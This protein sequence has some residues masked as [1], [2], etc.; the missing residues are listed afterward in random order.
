MRN[1][2]SILTVLSLVSATV[3]AQGVQP[4]APA[5]PGIPGVLQ[6]GA[7]GAVQGMMNAGGAPSLIPQQS[8]LQQQ[9]QQAQLAQQQAAQQQAQQQR[10]VAS[11]NGTEL[12][13][14]AA[15]SNNLC[16]CIEGGNC[17]PLNDAS[18]KAASRTPEA[19]H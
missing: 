5:T 10:Q 11:A 6:A 18:L 7:A 4:G 8:Q 16:S 2:S 13:S 14:Q 17:G 3:F 1:F 15:A 12:N 19:R 9:Q